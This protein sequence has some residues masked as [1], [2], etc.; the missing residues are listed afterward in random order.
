VCREIEPDAGSQ[1]IRGFISGHGVG[2]TLEQRPQ[3]HSLFGRTRMKDR[4]ARYR[5]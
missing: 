4:P 5:C 3:P 2:C 1:I